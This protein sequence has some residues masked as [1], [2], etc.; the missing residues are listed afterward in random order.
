MFLRSSCRTSFDVNHIA[1]LST[2]PRHICLNLLLTF[3]CGLPCDQGCNLFVP[4][5]PARWSWVL[6][7]NI[8][9]FTGCV[10]FFLKDLQNT[11]DW[12][13]LW[14]NFFFTFSLLSLDKGNSAYTIGHV[15][16]WNSTIWKAVLIAG[17]R[18]SIIFNKGIRT[19]TIYQ[20]ILHVY[21]WKSSD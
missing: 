17:D 8:M 15:L 19:L 12:S 9:Q 6:P 7:L 2:I 3:S 4:V 5:I 20:H 11:L 21:V 10:S 14:F 13:D 16:V 18:G 1:D